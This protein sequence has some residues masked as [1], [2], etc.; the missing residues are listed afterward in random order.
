MKKSVWCAA[1]LFA[2][3]CLVPRA[4]IPQDI[5]RGKWKAKRIGD[6][7]DIRMRIIQKREFGDWQFSRYFRE[8]DFEEFAWGKE[9][10]FRL[11]REAGTFAFEGELSEESG[12]GS[13]AFHPNSEFGNFLAE[14]GFADV[15]DK[16]MLMFCLNDITRKYIDDLFALGYSD[17]SSSKLISFAIHDVSIDFIKGIQALGYK[18]ISPSQLVSFSHP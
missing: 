15:K 7:I 5:I 4:V 12:T 16:E 14:K 2:F 3:V 11:V 6:K 13:F 9:A 1:I 10:N 17:I 18:D 8:S